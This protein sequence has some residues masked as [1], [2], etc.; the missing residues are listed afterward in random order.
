MSARLLL[1]VLIG[2]FCVGCEGL[3]VPPAPQTGKPAEAVYEAYIRFEVKQFLAAEPG[4]SPTFYVTLPEAD[5]SPE[6][7]AKL[8]DLPVPVAAGSQFPGRKADEDVNAVFL[9]I[10]ELQWEGDDQVR[11]IGKPTRLWGPCEKCGTPYPTAL[12]RRNGTWSVPM[13]E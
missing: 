2:A 10:Q 8:R 12:V 4:K 9:T 7:L 3:G 5:P 6:L 1:F 13:P 11:V